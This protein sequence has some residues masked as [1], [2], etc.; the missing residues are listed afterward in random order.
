MSRYPHWQT[1]EVCPVQMQSRLRAALWLCVLLIS[2][3]VVM[4]LTGQY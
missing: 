4:V 3:N 2:I 1:A